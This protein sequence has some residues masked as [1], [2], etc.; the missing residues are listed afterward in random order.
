MQPF[1]L[2]DYCDG[3]K[4]LFD[5]SHNINRIDIPCLCFFA[6]RM[7]LKLSLKKEGAQIG[8]YE[9]D[10]MFLSEREILETI[11]ELQKIGI[12]PSMAREF[13]D[14]IIMKTIKEDL[15]VACFVAG[16]RDYLNSGKKNYIITQSLSDCFQHTK[17]NLKGK[18]LPNQLSGYLELRDKTFTDADD[19]K[20]LGG[21]FFSIKKTEDSHT[22]L[23]SHPVQSG[24]IA[25]TLLS[26][27]D[28]EL[29]KDEIQRQKF[30]H[31]SYK[32]VGKKQ[33]KS[34][35]CEYLMMYHVI[36]NSIIYI[37]HECSELD[38]EVNFFSSKKTK[39]EFQENHF[40]R[41]PYIVV[42]RNFQMPKIFTSD[43]S[44]VMG[45]FKWRMG[46]E[47]RS[48][49]KLIWWNPHTRHYNTFLNKKDGQNEETHDPL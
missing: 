11:Y 47:G 22:I 39:R 5:K 40:T 29:I 44:S 6:K 42:G 25:H 19:D 32:E 2:P 14:F 21:L 4:L 10:F 35:H 13:Y 48:M 16:Y 49:L 31:Y 17:L 28:D 33:V 38:E 9:F 24:A 12:H 43:S 8:K 37:G 46:G 23:L 36:M 18:H 34:E 15:G 26:V 20:I 45:H 7:D 3:S 41:K 1:L 27:K 30:I